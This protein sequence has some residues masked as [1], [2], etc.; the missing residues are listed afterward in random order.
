MQEDMGVK[1]TEIS[2]HPRGYFKWKG[3]SCIRRLREIVANYYVLVPGFILYPLCILIPG[4]FYI[5]YAY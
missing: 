1:S 4:L 5:L 2:C 3:L